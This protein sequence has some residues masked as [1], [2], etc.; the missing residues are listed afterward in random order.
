MVFYILEPSWISQVL[1]PQEKSYP[2][3]T[4]ENLNTPKKYIDINQY[5]YTEPLW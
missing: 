5:W 3:K 2:E 1:Y 4:Y